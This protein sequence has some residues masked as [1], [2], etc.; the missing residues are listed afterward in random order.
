VAITFITNFI[1][2]KNFDIIKT[3]R[4]KKQEL[5]VG[6]YSP[7]HTGQNLLEFFECASR[8]APDMYTAI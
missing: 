5:H 7:A 8:F 2:R 3:R 6:L 1:H 4:A